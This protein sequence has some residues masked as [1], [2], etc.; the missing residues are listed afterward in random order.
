MLIVLSQKIDTLSDYADEVFRTYHFPA[1]YRNQIHEGDTYVYYQGNR[2]VK[3]QRYYFGIGK[4]GEITTQN[5][6]DYYAK[7]TDGCEFAIKVPI[8]LPNGEYVEQLGFDSVRKRPTPPWQ[9]SIRPISQQAFDY[10]VSNA[11]IQ[12]KRSTASVEGLKEKLKSSIRIFFL[13]KE[14]GAIN[15]I[16]NTATELINI[17]E[18]SADGSHIREAPADVP[19]VDEQE[20]IQGFIRYCETTRTAYSYKL[21]LLLAFFDCANENGVLSMKDAIRWTRQYYKIRRDNNL[22]VEMK[23]S[24]YLKSDMSDEQILNNLVNNQIKALTGSGYF[25]YDHNKQELAFIPDLW[26]S[27]GGAERRLIEKTCNHR[28]KL[29]YND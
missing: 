2:Y 18:G 16:K 27:I 20:G 12:D 25:T 1:R 3:E 19:A 6:V 28:L 7:L 11:C 14:D 5:G 8:Y 4:V 29:Y 9:S 21:V 13:D 24:I 15:D 10:I 26:P 17:L 22:P 23:R